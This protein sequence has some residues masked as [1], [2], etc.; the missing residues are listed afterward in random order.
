M[1][2]NIDKFS[3]YIVSGTEFVLWCYAFERENP[4]KAQRQL[5]INHF[6]STM[7]LIKFAYG[8]RDLEGWKLRVR[9]A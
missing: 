5:V 8:G 7:N 2:N 4:A 9:E 3:T 6:V 1:E